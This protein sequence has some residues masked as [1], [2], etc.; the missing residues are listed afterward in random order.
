MVLRDYHYLLNNAYRLGGELSYTR[1]GIVGNNSSLFVAATIDYHK[2]TSC[3][4]E[5]LFGNRKWLVVKAGL[6]F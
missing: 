5:Y 2:A 1:K 3:P 4:A 6:T